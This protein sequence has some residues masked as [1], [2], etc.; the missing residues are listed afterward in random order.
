MITTRPRPLQDIAAEVSRAQALWMGASTAIVSAG[1][2]TLATS[3]II[4][5]FF[6]LIPGLLA[7]LATILGARHV[8]DSGEQ[9]V[10]PVS[11]PQDNQ[12]RSLVPTPLTPP[13]ARGAKLW[14]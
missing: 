3:E 13:D 2:I 9:L 8:A 12:G 6:G 10:T 1:F 5:A 4:T 7:V 14:P 11:D